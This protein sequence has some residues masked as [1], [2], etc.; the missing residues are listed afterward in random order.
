MKVINAKEVQ[1][2]FGNL[3]NSAIKAPV[4]INKY[5]KPFSVLMSYEAY[6]YL[7][8]LEDFYWVLQ[9]EQAKKNGMLTQKETEEFLSKILEE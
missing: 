5:G 9:A 7:S 2:N 6:E 1:N 8:K 4:V 3:M